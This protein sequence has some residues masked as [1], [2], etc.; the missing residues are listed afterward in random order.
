M[1]KTKKVY[2]NAE[3][4]EILQNIATAYEIKNKNFFRIRSYQDAADTILTY[5]KS[6][7]SLWQ[8]DPKLLDDI[9][10]IGPNIFSKIVYLFE[11]GKLHPHIIRAFKNISPIVFTFT[12]I[13]GI[14]PKIAHT[15]TQ[16]LKFSQ[17]PIKAL[18]QLT[19]Y[20]QKGKIRNFPRFGVKSEKMILDN[21]LAFLGRHR[22][23]SYQE[24]K[25]AADK[26]INY[27]H[28]KFPHV[29]IEALGSLR[30]QTKTV[31]DIDLAAKSTQTKDILD[32]FLTYP[33]N[34]QTINRGPKKASIRIYPDIRVDLMVQPSKNFYSLVQHFTGS[35]QHNIL[36]RKYALSLG[37]SISEYGI[38]DLKTGKIN[39]FTS[40]EKL[41]NFLKLCFIPPQN[42]T[43]T[44]EIETAQK[45]YNQSLK[46]KS[47]K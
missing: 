14:G 6:V 7:H 44:T 45:C 27:L 38:K 35:K 40:E 1:T 21:T 4:A 28:K 15:L 23:L 26:I 37:L 12:K 13:N 31:G 9:P 18:N 24:A 46:I 17:D 2:S 19:I 25:T 43:G 36:L 32:Y 20:A 30:R 22:R 42:R 8:K 11:T 16:K 5:P 41:Y 3:V 34:I 33:K 29:K 10:G 39:T 47:K